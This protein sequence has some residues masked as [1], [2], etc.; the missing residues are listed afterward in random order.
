LPIDDPMIRLFIN[1]LAASAGGGLTYLRNVIPQLARRKD[2]EA[3]VALN[4]ALRQEFGTFPNIAFAD[5][6]IPGGTVGRFVR[7]QTMLPGVIRRS[8][9]QVLISAGNFALW[10]S[11]VPQILLSRN[12]LYTSD[13]FIRD[14]RRRGDYAIWSDTLVKG[15]LARQSIARAEVTV[16]P[17]AAFARELTEWTGKKVVALHHGFDREAFTRDATPLPPSVQAQLELGLERGL[18]PRKDA[19]RLLFVSHYNYYRNFETLLRAMPILS[20]RLNGTKARLFLTCRLD[21]RENPGT[22]R[23][24]SAASLV[25]ELRASQEVVELGMVAYSSLHH[26][27]RACDIYVAPAYS[28]SFAHPLVEAMSCGLPVVASDLPVHREICADAGVYFG[29]FS[30]EEL[31]D[32]VL[33]IHESPE[34][35]QPLSQNGIRR[36]QDFSWSQHV[37]RLMDLAGELV[38]T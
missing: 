32:K 15:W 21:S 34:L 31:A 16:A 20:R 1:G 25:N 23:A 18:E 11:P 33:Q 4:S 6:S 17:S 10:R 19:L 12:S 8:G 26:L 30:P 27:Y 5:A 36:S 38:T 22:Y 37:E 9:A 14:V 28:E 24:E 29:R 13:D 2:V 35:A 7:E 3:T